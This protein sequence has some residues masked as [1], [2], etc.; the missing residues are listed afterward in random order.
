MSGTFMSGLLMPGFLSSALI[1]PAQRSSWLR[2][3]TG[4][5]AARALPA[6]PEL[7]APGSAPDPAALAAGVETI[8]AVRRPTWEPLR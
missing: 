4:R 1:V 3:V 8:G 2:S 7:P 5:S 6:T